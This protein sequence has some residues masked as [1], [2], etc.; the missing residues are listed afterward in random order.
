MGSDKIRGVYKGKPLVHHALASLLRSHLVQDVVLVTKPG[1]SL[2][3]PSGDISVV[4]NPDHDEGMGASLRVGVAAAPAETDA[5]VFMLGDMPEVTVELVTHVIETWL[6][7]GKAI[8]VP[9]YQGRH[10]HPVLVSANLRDMLLTVSGDVGAREL[11]RDH[12]EQVE[13][14]PTDHPGCVFDID[15]PDDWNRRF[16]APND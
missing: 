13:F 16:G 10:G 5:L 7:T 6:K 1:F 8:V 11:I 2:P 14:V 15:T 3:L 9:T 4:P 12:V